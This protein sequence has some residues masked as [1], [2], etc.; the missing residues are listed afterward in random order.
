MSYMSLYL[1][2]VFS[3]ILIPR[4]GISSEF[5]FEANVTSMSYT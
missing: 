4:N 3:D 2:Y 1:A 5:T